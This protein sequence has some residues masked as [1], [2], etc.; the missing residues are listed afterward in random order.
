MACIIP[1]SW[2]AGRLGDEDLQTSFDALLHFPFTSNRTA[3]QCN[4]FPQEQALLLQESHHLYPVW[5]TAP[6]TSESFTEKSA[7]KAEQ[8]YVCT[9]CRLIF[10]SRDEWVGCEYSHYQQEEWKCDLKISSEIVCSESFSYQEHFHVA[11]IANGY[12][13]GQQLR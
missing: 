10:K 4:C 3:P 5:Y 12:S 1:Q 6:F 11:R 9:G 2:A 7:L 13:E 8:V